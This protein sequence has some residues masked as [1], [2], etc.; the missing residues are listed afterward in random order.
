MTLQAGTSVLIVRLA[1]EMKKVVMVERRPTG[2]KVA[3]ESKV[4]G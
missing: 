2:C 3:G 1:C 4:I